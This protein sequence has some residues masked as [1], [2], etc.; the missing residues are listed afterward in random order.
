ME[1]GALRLITRQSEGSI[2]DSLSLLDQILSFSSEKITEKQVQEILG[3]VDRRI[4]VEIGW[5]ITGKSG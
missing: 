5:A 3:F 1:E 4:I 2:R